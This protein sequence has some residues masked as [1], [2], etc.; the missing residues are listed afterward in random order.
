M[1]S[2]MIGLI[3]GALWIALLISALLYT[4]VKHQMDSL[5]D[6]VATSPAVCFV[7]RQYGAMTHPVDGEP[8]MHI[9]GL[10]DHV[11]VEARLVYIPDELLR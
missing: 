11:Y 2:L 8:I 1:P 10:K 7:C 3:Y 4:R 9:D 5:T 6:L